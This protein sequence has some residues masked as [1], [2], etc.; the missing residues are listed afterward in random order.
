MHLSMPMQDV[1]RM[2]YREPPSAQI[3]AK[4]TDTF[5]KETLRPLAISAV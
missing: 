3:T 4:F 2:V 5:I 1:L